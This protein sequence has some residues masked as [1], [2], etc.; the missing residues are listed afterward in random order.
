[1]KK[2]IASLSLAAA[3]LAGCEARF[4]ND[5]APVAENATAAGRAE[6]GRLT[7]EANGFNLSIDI[8]ASVR[9]DARA[10]DD[11]GLLYPGASLSGM[12][13]QGSPDGRRGHD[14]EVELRFTSADPPERVAAWYRDPARAERLTVQSAR[15]EGN[16]F[17]IAGIGRRD[18]ERFTV[19]IEPRAGGGSDSRLVLAD[20]H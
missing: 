6:E 13:V 3:L 8:P 19:R 4:G 2:T 1:M 18:D 9:A 11:S 14:G 5:A 15:R 10:D 20:G 16:A 7:V 17:V 12:H